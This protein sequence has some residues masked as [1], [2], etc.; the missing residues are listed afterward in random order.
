MQDWWAGLDPA[1]RG[2]WLASY[3]QGHMPESLLPTLPAGQRSGE[4]DRWVHVT[5]GSAAGHST[6]AGWTF[7]TGFAEFLATKLEESLG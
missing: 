5:G 1:I 7:H 6:G 3:E 4:A 2:L